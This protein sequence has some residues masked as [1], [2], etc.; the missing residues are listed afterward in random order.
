MGIVGWIGVGC[1]CWC[2]VSCGLGLVTAKVLAVP[3][4]RVAASDRAAAMDGRHHSGST[5]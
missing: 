2:V 1:A 3:D 4:R 5:P